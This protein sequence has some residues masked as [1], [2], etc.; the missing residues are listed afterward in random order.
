M[1][2]SQPQLL[3]VTVSS[4]AAEAVAVTGIT[5]YMGTEIT[6]ALVDEGWKHIRGTSRKSPEEARTYLKRLISY[7]DGKGVTVDLMQA[8]V[9]D[10]EAVKKAV[11]EPVVSLSGGS[12]PPMIPV[13]R[14]I[15]TAL[16]YPAGNP[17]RKNA[18]KLLDAAVNGT[19]NVLRSCASADSKVKQVV[20]TCS[21]LSIHAGYAPKTFADGNS[22]V[23]ADQVLTVAGG[24]PKESSTKTRTV[25]SLKE[26]TNFGFWG[27]R[28]AEFLGE[29]VSAKHLSPGGNFDCASTAGKKVPA[30][31]AYAAG[32]SLQE[33]AAWDWM[34]LH[35]SQGE[36]GNSFALSCVSIGITWGASGGAAGNKVVLSKAQFKASAGCGFFKTLLEN[37][38]AMAPNACYIQTGIE[39]AALAH[40]NC[41]GNPKA[42]GKR[43][44]V[45][46]AIVRPGDSKEDGKKGTDGGSSDEEQSAGPSLADYCKFDFAYGFNSGV[47]AGLREQNAILAQNGGADATLKFKGKVYKGVSPGKAVP[48]AMGKM[49]CWFG[50][51]P[52]HVLKSWGME[53]ALDEAWVQRTHDILGFKP[54]TIGTTL[55]RAISTFDR[56]MAADD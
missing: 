22:R 23:S 38:F 5:G 14:V 35:E 33:R 6:R 20:M 12:G 2:T 46:C 19:F 1:M 29:P 36:G 32:K 3:D 47:N 40:A 9:C 49:I 18:N 48:L 11:T 21:G 52:S 27:D 28:L 16:Q 10:E 41:L 15:H 7:C 26:D 30:G 42:T 43:L 53:F 44:P 34:K 17:S 45:A 13:T 24:S 8:D 4:K 54:R 31:H 55:G 37:G 39:D 25:Y 51:L 56:V 50:M